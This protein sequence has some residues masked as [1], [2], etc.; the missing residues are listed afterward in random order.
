MSKPGKRAVPPPPPPAAFDYDE[1]PWGEDW[2]PAAAAAAAAA[3]VPA[4]KAKLPVPALPLAPPV[5]VSRR[6]PLPPPPPPAARYK[7]PAKPVQPPIVVSDDDAV[8]AAAAGKY[9]APDDGDASL[10]GLGAGGAGAD[11]IDA[12]A[13]E[14]ARDAARA[15]ASVFKRALVKMPIAV[16][17]AARAVSLVKL[18]PLKYYDP[19]QPE[20]GKF[21]GLITDT[22]RTEGKAAFCIQ[23][24]GTA[25]TTG[26]PDTDLGGAIKS[27][28]FV[29]AHVLVDLDPE[30]AAA[31]LAFEAA[32]LAQPSTMQKLLGTTAPTPGAAD[33]YA[34]IKHGVQ[35][36]DKEERDAVAK[37]QYTGT[38]TYLSLRVPGY[39]DDAIVG[40]EERKDDNPK[41]V[42]AVKWRPHVRVSGDRF[43]PPFP[44][45]TARIYKTE[46]GVTTET[47]PLL[48]DD[49][50]PAVAVGRDGV[51]VAVQA[52][53]SPGHI[54]KGDYLTLSIFPKIDARSGDKFAFMYKA[55]SI[56]FEPAPEAAPPVP[57]LSIT[58]PYGAPAEDADDALLAAAADAVPKPKPAGGAPAQKLLTAST[59][60]VEALAEEDE[61]AMAAAAE[62][63][64][65]AAPPKKAGS[66]R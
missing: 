4:K 27:G 44:K 10:D 42:K 48:R 59:R 47:T 53:Y 6:L 22:S 1:E 21:S 66:R 36:L 65:A 18:T 60:E 16:G 54:S 9:S 61:E 5:E 52:A 37:G 19:K 7:A 28:E 57:R 35:P 51:R 11:A 49:G 23:V 32:L 63:E 2:A 8:P 64:A 45:E 46:D 14:I 17:F 41:F 12:L 20:K 25:K 3:P 58:D 15:S 34:R 55:R 29:P 38:P 26:R 62:A 43:A 33:A 24:R 31:L 13:V 56:E 40:T 39:G 50:T 30:D